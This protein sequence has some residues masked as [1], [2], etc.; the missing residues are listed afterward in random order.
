M[1]FFTPH[2]RIAFL[3]TA[4][5]I[6]TQLSSAQ[7]D[8]LYEGLEFDMPRVIV[9]NFPANSVSIVDFGAIGDGQTLNTKAFAQAIDAISTKGGGRVV[10]PR[11]IWLAG[12]II[13]KSNIDLHAEAGALVLFSKNKDHY[14]II[15]TSFE[16]LDTM[17]CTSPIYGKDLTNIAITGEGIFDGSG[18]VWRKVKKEK[19]TANQWN[20]LLELGGS[21]DPKG[22][23]WYPSEQYMRADQK[24]GN[25]PTELNTLAEFQAVR[26]LLRPVMVSLVSCKNVLLDGPVFQNSPAWCI[27]LLMCENLTV[28]NIDVRNPWYSANG[29]GIDIESCKN[30]I[31]TN[32]RFDVGDDAICIKSGRDEDGRNRG[33]PTENLIVKNCTV[34]NGHGGFTVG[35][36]MSGGVKNMHVSNCTFI[37]TDVGLRFKSTRGRGGIVEGVYISNIDM[38]NIKTRAI[39]FNLYYGGESVSEMLA[40]KSSA[41]TEET[42]PV[43]AE[44]PQFKDIFIRDV[45]CKGAQQ[46]IYL[47][48]LPEMSLQNVNLSNMLFE[49]EV[50]LL[51][52]DTDGIMVDG[53]TLITSNSPAIMLYNTQ[54]VRMN[55]LSLSGSDGELIKI[56]GP[57]SQNIGIEVSSNTNLSNRFSLGDSVDKTSITISRK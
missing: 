4:L 33:M 47:Q 19:T 45:T 28:R 7:D 31:I 38:T 43:T 17:R 29:D 5:G 1:N 34:Y 40:K 8:S 23:I 54:N 22:T 6:T 12:P 56:Q 55:D 2:F 32:C 44:T 16:G 35:S 18:E 20:D 13:L 39:S 27:H 11:G 10:I 51:A 48:G 30:T 36:E 49:C 50:G 9:P 53:V 24:G 3:V 15:Q 52:M 42:I 21:L 25:V 57:R 41:S 14:P 46:A 26:D 37:G